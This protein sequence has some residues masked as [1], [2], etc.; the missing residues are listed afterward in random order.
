MSTSDTDTSSAG[1][2]WAPASCTLPTVE[3]PI[4]A[5]E[6]DD[7][8]TTA[9]RAAERIDATT[10]RLDLTT[11]AEAR[12]R[13]LASRE[14]NCCSFF[15]FDFA[16]AGDVVEMTVTVRAAHIAVLDAFAARATGH[17]TPVTG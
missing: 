1:L 10:L 17:L 4:R 14:S 3:Q 11:D 12:A 2:G 16:P 13:D 9:V 8:F 6:F 5:A 7:L 15:G